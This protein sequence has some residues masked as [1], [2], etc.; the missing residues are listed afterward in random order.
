MG[1]RVYDIF[2]ALPTQHVQVTLDSGTANEDSARLRSENGCTGVEE[3][4]YLNVAYDSGTW[5]Y[6]RLCTGCLVGH[7]DSTRAGQHRG[8]DFRQGRAS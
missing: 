6:V 8:P 5:I 3:L 7:D 4:P 2:K 1:F